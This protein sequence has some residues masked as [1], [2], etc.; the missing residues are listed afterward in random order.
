MNAGLL[1]ALLARG[2]ITPLTAKDLRPHLPPNPQSRANPATKALLDQLAAAQAAHAAAAAQA[3]AAAKE[4]L[5]A[6]D[7][8]AASANIPRSR[9][10]RFDDLQ[11]SS[12]K[13]SKKKHRRSNTVDALLDPEDEH[14][15]PIDLESSAGSL[16]TS[17]S[18]SISSAGPRTIN[19]PSSHLASRSQLS[20]LSLSLSNHPARQARVT[21]S[22]RVKQPWVVSPTTVAWRESTGG[23]SISS[24]GIATDN[25]GQLEQVIA[26]QQIELDRSQK[27]EAELRAA[28][29]SLQQQVCDLLKAQNERLNKVI[30]EQRREIQESHAR[31]NELKT[32]V[33]ELMAQVAQLKQQQ[34]R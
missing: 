32:Q 15:V 18:T 6:S 23:L 21:H 10:Q 13:K 30:E 28:A 8:L 20:A 9:S 16:P 31:Q 11:D 33:S 7:A 2:G 5:A 25:V 4:A 34:K 26:A 22:P 12:G 14:A 3:A 1:A 17:T 27:I 19:L 24:D 29:N